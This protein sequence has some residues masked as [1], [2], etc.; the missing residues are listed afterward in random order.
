M[1]H[2]RL[3]KDVQRLKNM[4]VAWLAE[5]AASSTVEKPIFTPE[6]VAGHEQMWS[7]DNV[8]KYPYQLINPMTGPDGQEVVSGPVAYTKAPQIPAAMAALMQI[9][10]VDMAEILGNQQEGDKMVSNISGKAVEMIQQ[11]LDMQAFIY[12]SNF[13]KSMQWCGTVWLSM[14]KELYTEAKRRMKLIGEMDNIESVELAEPMVV[15]GELTTRNDL[16]RADFDVVSDVG[17]SFTSRRDATVRGLTGVLQM[18]ED[19]QDK[20]ILNSLILM[21]MEGEGLGDVREYYRKKL[22]TLGVLQPNEEE[23]AEMEEAAA[24]QQPSAQDQYLLA[25]AGKKAAE[26]EESRA[27]TGLKVAKTAET[28]ANTL[29]ILKEAGAPSDA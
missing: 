3:A 9:L 16:S 12:M 13:A 11:R 19:P 27:D 10:D 2:V 25:E 29:K 8:K 17:P 23:R 20:S 15:E 6:Q 24:N 14:A 22:V 18:T 21:N 4:V 1:G 26:T 28:E 5:I 7:E